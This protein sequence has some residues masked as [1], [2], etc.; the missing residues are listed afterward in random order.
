MT[1]TAVYVQHLIVT[2]AN[3][4]DRI[5]STEAL[6]IGGLVPL[7]VRHRRDNPSS[8]GLSK[9]LEILYVALP[10]AD[11]ARLNKVLHAK[12]VDYWG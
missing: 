6:G 11:D 3:L 5:A 10:R 9:A 12:V 2:D 4:A 8:H 1:L 7:N